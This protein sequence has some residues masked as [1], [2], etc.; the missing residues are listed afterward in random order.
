MASF[1]LNPRSERETWAEIDLSAHAANIR[2]LRARIPATCRF[3]SVVKANAYGHGAASIARNALSNGAAYLGVATPLEGALLRAAGIEAPIVVLSPTSTEQV[4][5][6]VRNRLMPAVSSIAMVKALER[7]DTK[8]HVKVNTGMNRSGIEPGEVEP[9][10]RAIAAMDGVEAEGIFSHLAGA[11]EPNRHSAYDQFDRFVGVLRAIEAAGLR[12]RIAHIANSAAILDM[13]EMALDMVRAG[14]AQYGLFPSNHVSRIAKLKPV[15][16]WKASVVE[17]R[18]LKA[19]DAVSYAGTFVAEKPTT[20]ALLT[21]GYADGYRRALSNKGQ[22]LLKGKRCPVA[23][24]VCMDLTVVDC[25]DLE[26]K[27]GDE[28]V[29]IGRQGDDAISADEMATWLGTINYEV[30]TQITERVPRV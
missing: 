5:I 16:T 7:T 29:L 2:A 18:R 30:T 6:I 3:M 22:V 20:I 28:A 10:L 8:V 27:C 26:V 23:G 19:G 4:E 17:C 12:P 9:F 24:R 21:I 15:L 11:D 13:P 14:I 25:G 1:P